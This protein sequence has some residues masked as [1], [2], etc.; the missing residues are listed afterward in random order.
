MEKK[1]LPVLLSLFLITIGQAYAEE[2]FAVRDLFN[3]IA[4][5]IIC[6]I[7]YVILAACAVTIVLSGARYMSSDDPTVR[8]DMRRNLKYA[9]LGLVLVFAGI[10]TINALVNQTKSPFFCITCSPDAQLFK[11]VAETMSCRV[12]C[13]VQYVAGM[14]L[15]LILAFAGLRYM[16]SGDDPKTRHDMM[17]WIKNALVGVLIVI[18]AVP[19]LNEITDWTGTSLECD[20]SAGGGG[21]LSE[22]YGGNFAPATAPA[23]SAAVGI[24]PAPPEGQK[25]AS[26]KK[27]VPAYF[28]ASKSTPAENIQSYSWDFGDGTAPQTGAAAEHKYAEKG[29]YEATVTITGKNG[30]TS[31]DKVTVTVTPA[32]EIIVHDFD[33]IARMPEK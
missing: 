13:L 27:N 25:A 18:L 16:L 6:V 19:V 31:T 15:V 22:L 21:L 7:E 29:T 20:C 14:I 2:Y 33:V 8:T 1:Y 4:C 26:V 28:D 24:A 23:A 30:K 10:P 11:I 17:S 5:N 9:M 12:I 3:N 32:G